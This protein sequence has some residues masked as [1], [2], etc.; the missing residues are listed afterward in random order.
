MVDIALISAASF[1]L[2]CQDPK[3]TPFYMTLEEIDREI[4]DRQIT[5][6]YAG[7][8]NAELI[9]CKLPSEHHDLT[10][11]FSEK[12]SN[13]LPLHHMIDHKIILEQEN[14]LGFSL[15]YHMSTAELQTMKQYLLDNQ[16]G[17]AHV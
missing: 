11:I 14:S 7:V 8:T 16:I 3:A 12:E 10:N 13:E 4:T 15:L 1:H 9:D 17:R 5:D 6:A 2:N